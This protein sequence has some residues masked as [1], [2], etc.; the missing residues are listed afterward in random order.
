MSRPKTCFCKHINMPF[1]GRQFK[2]IRS[3]LKTS[4]EL[5]AEEIEVIRLRNL[6]TI[7]QKKSARKLHTS[8]STVQRLLSSAYSKIADALINGKI[9]KMVKHHG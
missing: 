5:S 6:L 7:S 2:P 4:V 9:I 8:Q 3:S 1:V